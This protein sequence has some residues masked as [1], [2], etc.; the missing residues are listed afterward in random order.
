MPQP[1]G[2]SPAA[3]PPTPRTLSHFFFA[4]VCFADVTVDH[5]TREIQ[6]PKTELSTLLYQCFTRRELERVID[7]CR[8]VWKDSPMAVVNGVR[9]P[10]AAVLFEQAQICLAGRPQEY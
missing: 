6:L 1:I 5:H 9:R 2:R 7:E 3:P 4:G 10:F 8:R